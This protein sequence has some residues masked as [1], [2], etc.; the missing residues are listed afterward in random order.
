MREQIF[1]PI[2]PVLPVPDM[3]AAIEFVNAR[4]KPLAVYLFSNNGAV[5]DEILERT[6]MGTF[7]LKS[8]IR[9]FGARPH[10]GKFC[11]LTAEEAAQLYPRLAD[12]RAIC[13][14]VDPHGVFQ[15]DFTRRVLGFGDPEP[16]IDSP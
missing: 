11:P 7:L 3:N 10:W 6:G 13:R 9:L 8:M 5:G 14:R 4:P 15:N 1:G 2:L 16:G 12:F